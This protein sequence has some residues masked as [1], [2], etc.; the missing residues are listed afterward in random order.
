MKLTKKERDRFEGLVFCLDDE[1]PFRALEYLVYLKDFK[2]FKD[3]AQ[4][5]NELV[6]RT[7]EVSRKIREIADANS[8]IHGNSP[9]EL[10]DQDEEGVYMESPNWKEE[11]ND[12][13]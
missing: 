12:E 1:G 4:E 10:L 7:K 8:I 9:E 6:A 5:A 11:D 3:L 2:K 13:E